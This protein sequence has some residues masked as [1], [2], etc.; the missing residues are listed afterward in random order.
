MDGT[1][2]MVSMFITEV[3]IVP[4]TL[5]ALIGRKFGHDCKAILATQK[6]Q[7][8]NHSLPTPICHCHVQLT[9]SDRAMS[10][11]APA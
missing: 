1:G 8:L 6:L 2:A 3:T 7:V 4:N 10:R 9:P 11:L 5:V